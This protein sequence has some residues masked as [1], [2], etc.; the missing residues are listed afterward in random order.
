ME[1]G[2]RLVRPERRGEVPPSVQKLRVGGCPS[3]QKSTVE[4]GLRNRKTEREQKIGRGSVS[5]RMLRFK[6]YLP[7]ADHLANMAKQH[8][9]ERSGSVS[10]SAFAAN[11]TYFRMTYIETEIRVK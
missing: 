2:C 10:Y 11:R 8:V 7:S 3:V 9:G 6:P 4:R 1:G 5:V